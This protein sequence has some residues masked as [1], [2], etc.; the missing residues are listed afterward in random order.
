[1]GKPAASK[2]FDDCDLFSMVGTDLPIHRLVPPPGRQ[3]CRSTSTA[4]ALD[5]GRRFMRIW[6]RP[7]STDTARPPGTCASPTTD[8]PHLRASE[9][10]VAR[11]ARRQQ[12]LLDPGLRHDPRRQAARGVRQPRRPDP[13][14]GAGGGARPAR[15]PRR[16]LHHRHRDVDRV[17]VALR[18]DERPAAAA[19][20][21]R[22][23]ARWPTPSRRLSAPR[24]STA[25][26]RSSRAP[27]T[28]A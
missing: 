26:A 18:D 27:A 16:H 15:R 4:R 5:A 11:V 24:R 19:R 6:S 3:S 25:T 22:T 8:N 17:G 23:S 1:M 13:P 28:A 21:A 14:R 20:L 10:G 12:A 2:A 9:R 7:R